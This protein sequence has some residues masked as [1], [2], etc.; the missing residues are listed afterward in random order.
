MGLNI[1][2]NVSPDRINEI[3]HKNLPHAALQ[4]IGSDPLAEFSKACVEPGVLCPPVGVGSHS[5]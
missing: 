1:R 5:R 3:S 2:Y 4:N